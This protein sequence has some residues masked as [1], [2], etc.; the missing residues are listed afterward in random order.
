MFP[1]WKWLKD[2][3]DKNSRY[4]TPRCFLNLRRF[5]NDISLR[6]NIHFASKPYF[7]FLGWLSFEN[8][9]IM[10][11]KCL[12]ILLITIE[13]SFGDTKIFAFENALT[14]F[15]KFLVMFLNIYEW[16]IIP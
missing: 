14:V 11:T 15:W 3:I 5:G 16:V 8:V 4:K 1:S 2:I 7:C 6:T 12:Q 13:H 10:F 9:S